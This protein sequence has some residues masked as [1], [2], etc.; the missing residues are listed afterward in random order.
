[1]ESPKFDG[2]DYEWQPDTYWE[3]PDPLSAILLNVKG[4]NR[5]QKIIHHWEAGTIGELDESLL[6]DTFRGYRGQ[7]LEMYHT[8]FMGGE[9]L[10]AL[11]ANQVEIARVESESTTSDVVSIRA[12][13]RSTGIRYLIVD[14]YDTTF[15]QPRQTSR[16][17]FLSR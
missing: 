11:K 12:T 1:M 15:H 4:T 10:P 17:P 2:I 13:R 8:S 5:R 14:Q 7:M 9:Y 16:R 6:S 3:V